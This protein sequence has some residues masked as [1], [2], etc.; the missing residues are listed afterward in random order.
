[1]SAAD[2]E[3]LDDFIRR[4]RI[5]LEVHMPRRADA[6]PSSGGRRTEEEELARVTECRRLQR[7]L[8]DG[9]LAGICV[10]PEYGGQG[11][12][13]AHQE[14]FNR[15]ITGYDYPAEI[16]VPTFTPCMAVILDSGTEEQ[17]QRHIPP[18]LRGEE[19]W[20]QFLSE[21]S[22]GSDVASART[23]AV[24]DGDGWLL[25][26]SKIWTTGAWWADWALCLARTNW[27]VPKH[28]GLT[29]LMLPIRQ[30]GIEIHRIEMVNGS[31]EFCQEYLTDVRVPDSDR[32]GEVDGGWTVGRRWMYHERT[33]NGGSPYVTRPDSLIRTLYGP[34]GGAAGLAR[35][36]KAAGYP[37][38]ATRQQA[39]GEA[40]ALELVG[41][42]LTRHVAAGIE[43]GTM[44]DQAAA[45][46]K[47]FAGLATARLI[48]LGYELAGPAAAAWDAPEQEE[49]AGVTYLMRQAMCIGGGT[50]EMN[51]QIV[52]ERVLGMPR[53]E[54]LDK[55]VPFRDVPRGPA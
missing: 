55:N 20:M 13:S 52:S 8:Y 2:M 15:L 39:V 43:G 9:G 6:A 4:A 31:R 48:Q 12:T 24:H 19:L 33:T 27:D 7:M 11:L 17:K 53:P 44:P 46:T 29:V 42:A 10:P 32:L 50:T 26:G 35:R 18:I 25:N 22:G 36:S 45:V 23:S 5:W 1:M 40:R 51:R 14:A 16:Q 21:P 30:P 37:D 3:P 34:P 47:L 38:D 41:S 28:R 49:A 54:S